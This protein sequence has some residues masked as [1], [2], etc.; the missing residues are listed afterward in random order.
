MHRR[1]RA[2]V[3]LGYSD[4]ANVDCQHVDFILM[5]KN[6]KNAKMPNYDANKPLDPSRSILGFLNL[7][8]LAASFGSDRLKGLGEEKSWGYM[9]V[10]DHRFFFSYCLC[11]CLLEIAC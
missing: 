8:F 7:N 6:K 5:F 3:D 10:T 4:G 2:V 1:H 11:F 9:V